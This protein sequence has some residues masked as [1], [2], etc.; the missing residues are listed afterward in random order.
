MI[1][2]SIRV[3][4]FL[5]HEDSQVEFDDAR[6]W[7]ITGHNGSGKSALFDAVEYALY[8]KH[9]GDS[10]NAELLVKQ[11]C[12][13]ALVEVMI[14]LNHERL[15]ICH[16]I[17]TRHGNHGGQIDR[18]N[19]NTGTWNPVNV[20]TG[21]KAVWEWL[22][23]RLPP[24]ELFCSAIYLRQNETAR[25]LSGSVSK[26]MERFAALIDLSRYTELS[27]RAAERRDELALRQRDNQTRLGDLGDL[28]D[29][30]LQKL[31]N[32]VDALDRQVD[33]ARQQAEV[34]EARRQ[35][36]KEW[37]RLNQRR[38]ELATQ[39]N[40][41]ETLLSSEREILAA[42]DH[43]RRW[44]RDAVQLHRL[45]SHLDTAERLRVDSEAARTEAESID[46]RH[47]EK[48]S[49]ISRFE[50]R[51]VEI[52]N[53]LPE[54]RRRQSLAE[55]C[56][57]GIELEAGIAEARKRLAATEVI[58]ERFSA[59]HDDLAAWRARQTSL[60]YLSALIEA[61]ASLIASQEAYVLAREDTERAQATVTTARVHAEQA[62]QQAAE[63]EQVLR[64]AQTRL[65]EL[66]T[67]LA[68]L[69]GKIKSH[70]RL[71][72]DEPQCPV[73]DQVLDATAHRHVQATLASEITRQR[74]LETAL[75]DASDA[76]TEAMSTTNSANE[77]T[78]RRQAT[79]EQAEKDYALAKQRLEHLESTIGR[80]RRKLDQARTAAARHC[81][82]YDVD[83][84]GFDSEWLANEHARVVR[85]I[86][87]AEA[88]VTELRKA[89]HAKSSDQGALNTLRDRRAPEVTPLGDELDIETIRAKLDEASREAD[90]LA[91][92]VKDLE[93]KNQELHQHLNTLTIEAAQLEAQACQKHTEAKKA[94]QE[95]VAEAVQASALSEALSP[96][97]ENVAHDRARYE[98]EQQE[99]ERLRE[100]ADQ[101]V[102][103]R[104]AP[105]LL[106][107][108]K[109]QL[110]EITAKIYQIPAEHR[111]PVSSAE[112]E[113]RRAEAAVQTLLLER[114]QAS[115][116]VEE[117]IERREQ[118]RK[119]EQA[120]EQLEHRARI[121]GDLANA[122]KERGPL[123]VK[124]V[125]DEQTN[126]VAET[127]TVLRRLGDP[128]TVSLGDPR[129][130]RSGSTMK[131]LCIIDTSDPA[132]GARYF[133]FLSG[134]EK[135]RIALA[136]AL[137][138]H[139]R[140]GGGN[141]GTLI[142]D[143]GFGALDSD[144]RDNLA[145]QMAADSHQG[146]LG[147]HLAESIIMC[148]H[149]SEVQRHFP[150]R[151]HVEKRD[152]TAS[153]SRVDVED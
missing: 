95:A 65:G 109:G 127:N 84:D 59:A 113:K 40:E 23:K 86:S 83:S 68:E 55:A 22:E 32:C 140:V 121:F 148:S 104:E 56:Q 48:Q 119:L 141:T 88:R 3:K 26:R 57:R 71:S 46:S 116:A 72:G 42:D 120:I 137:A 94:G 132:G 44:D 130:V 24:H 34:S 111:V 123:Q 66:K 135:F 103:L 33:E 63:H 25:F 112:D 9:R 150:N 106:E 12:Q 147:L 37:N 92:E 15:R 8:H 100:L 69:R 19:A 36:A 58:V 28:S 107:A 149:T 91:S 7:L 138:L 54:I 10:Q 50:A 51:L 115:H 61:R 139:R 87:E 18:W 11:G 35:N 67:E 45:W 93:Q 134:G 90:W 131:D 152:G 53:A 77:E 21:K 43:V 49:D 70:R 73:C 4:Q 153:V 136:L 52:L 39:Q 78:N 101:V 118:A 128:L 16:Q 99:V 105:G 79:L 108:L 2:E 97:W 81:T 20:G 151:W 60:P 1:I 13:T 29:E 64:E 38:Q 5:S 114:S 74:E 62:E 142:V 96:R 146:I 47:R 98:A 85:G 17:G 31:K 144:K 27:K 41:L 129:R 75:A 143:E 89:E 126:I 124:I 122:L 76:V 80:E 82:I 125:A 145:L 117:M 102:T 14:Q 110:T 133:E 6:L 30:A